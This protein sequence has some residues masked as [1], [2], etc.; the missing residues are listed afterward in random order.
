MTIA[1]QRELMPALVNPFHKM[2]MSLNAL[3][4]QKER[5]VDTVLCQHVQHLGRVARM[6]AIVKGQGDLAAGGI[7]KK[8]NAGMASLQVLVH[9]AKERREH[10]ESYFAFFQSPNFSAR[11]GILPSASL[12]VM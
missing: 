10:L 8:E 1:V 2:R 7:P 6:R 12:S 3:P 5:G 9:G 11:T 4:D